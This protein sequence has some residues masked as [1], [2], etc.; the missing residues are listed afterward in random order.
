[1][2]DNQVRVTFEPT[3]RSVSVLP[4]TK[5][6]E[7]AALAGLTVSTP[8]GGQGVCGKCRI[9]VVQG[10]KPAEP[11]KH[12]PLTE[13]E[14]KQGWRMGCQTFISSAAVINL[15]ESSLFGVGQQILAQRQ[16]GAAK[17][18]LPAVRKLYVEL[19]EPTMHD[20]DPDLLRLEK[21]IGPVKVGLDMLRRLPHLLRANGFK[22]TAV[23]T[24]HNLIDFQPGDT[25]SRC[26]GMAFD[27]GTTT[28]VGSLLDLCSGRELSIVSAVNPQVSFGDDVLSRIRHSGSCDGGLD[29][30]RKIV[31]GAVNELIDKACKEAGISRQDIL[32]ISFAGNT[33]MQHLLCGIDPTQLGQVPFTPSHHRGL[34]LRAA[35]LD[36]PIHPGAAAYVFPV[37]GGFVGG[38]TVA[39]LLASRLPELE[40]PV[41]MVDIGTN[42]EIV[43]AHQGAMFAASTAAGPAFE[44]ARISCG[45]RATNGAIEKVIIDSDVHVSTIGSTKPIGLCGSG[46]I[47]L[48]AG[49]LRSGLLTPEG[50]LLPKDEL[51]ASLGEGLA[52]RVRSDAQGQVEF[53]LVAKGEHDATA[54]VTVNQRDF[55]ELQLASGAIRAGIRILCSQA[56]LATA[57]LNRVLIAGGFGSFIRRSHAQRI[58]LLPTDVHHEKIHYVG[59]ASLDGAKWALLS[60][61][62]RQRAESYA[63]QALHVELSQSMDFQMEFAEAMIFPE[64]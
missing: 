20:N 11:G 53:V 17:E 13:P 28:I 10:A 36:L 22:G 58:G 32:E 41:L 33:T 25:T 18:V 3:G 52:S 8:C 50:R 1:M 39:G 46:L 61:Q 16:Q 12:G 21:K 30:L 26:H 2:S 63:S 34:L 47:D 14:L 31:L 7:A 24:D 35:D 19:T 56:G 42:G 49:M 48:A 54:E 5:V 29:Q 62:Q 43:L 57:D 23:L 60:T 27:I 59:N 37:I 64:S 9:Q 44:G 40:G 45:M 6:L 4:G 51:P 15:P 38:D 55:R